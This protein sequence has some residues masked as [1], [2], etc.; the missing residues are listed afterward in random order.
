MVVT[1]SELATG[2][3]LPHEFGDIWLARPISPPNIEKNYINFDRQVGAAGGTAFRR[4]RCAKHTCAPG[5]ALAG[6]LEARTSSL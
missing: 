6:I 4:Y 2:Q 1:D 3:N 5:D